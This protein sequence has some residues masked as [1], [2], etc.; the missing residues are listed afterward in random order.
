MSSF[1]LSI[2]PPALPILISKLLRNLQ[3]TD[4][5]VILIVN[6][7]DNE[8]RESDIFGFYNLG[9]GDPIPVSATLGR[10]IGD[11]LDKLIANFDTQETETEDNA[12]KLA[13]IGKENVGKSS[14]V[15]TL[16]RP[17]TGDCN[18]GSGNHA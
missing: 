1:S 18:P 13:V 2:N 9:L 11:M 14:F 15:N 6:K 12:I 10:G 3:R 5:P 16:F 8:K 4:I 17:G 7:V